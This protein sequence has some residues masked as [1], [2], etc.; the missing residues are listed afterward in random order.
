MT[1]AVTTGIDGALT[2][3]LDESEDVWSGL[4]SHGIA[5]NSPQQPDVGAERLVLASLKI[6]VRV[7]R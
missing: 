6:R 1:A 2:D 7:G 4:V 3:I 5:E